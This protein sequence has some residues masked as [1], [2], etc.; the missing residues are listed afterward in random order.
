[1]AVGTLVP[2]SRNKR[3]LSLD[4][5][6]ASNIKLSLLSQAYTPNALVD[7][8]YIWDQISNYEISA[9][10]G[11]S[12]GGVLLSDNLVTAVAG[13]FKFSTSDAAWAATGGPIPAWLYG[14]LRVNGSL[15]N[16][17]DPLIGYFIVDETQTPQP[18]TIAGK[19]LVIKC[20]TDGWFKII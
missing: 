16:L 19:P 3:K 7:G 10:N 17:T 20:P 15:W 2:Y 8:H 1:M 4:E 18:E 9:G 13:G 5:L 11:Y 6:A 12:Q 14:V